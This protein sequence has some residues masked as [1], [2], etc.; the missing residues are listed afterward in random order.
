MDDEF[1]SSVSCDDD[2]LMDLCSS[3][4]SEDHDEEE[5]RPGLQTGDEVQEQEMD[6]IMEE[7]EEVYEAEE[8]EVQA[9][10][11]ATIYP[12]L[13][14]LMGKWEAISCRRYENKPKMAYSRD[15]P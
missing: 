14:D 9:T 6:D 10:P 8:E 3:S 15:L 11:P 7:E 12:T 5:E 1:N 4:G 13:G 2:D